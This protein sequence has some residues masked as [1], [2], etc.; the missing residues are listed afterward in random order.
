MNTDS[1]GKRVDGPGTGTPSLPLWARTPL[2]MIP[3]Q[4]SKSSARGTSGSGW[5]GHC[6]P[7]ACLFPN[8]A[9]NKEAVSTP[10]VTAMFFPRAVLDALPQD[11]QTPMATFHQ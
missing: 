11:A 10:G 8:N 2:H 3:Q 6:A 9:V 5:Q 7:I 4:L 1:R